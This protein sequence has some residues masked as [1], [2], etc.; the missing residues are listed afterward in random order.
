MFVD[1]FISRP[2]FAIVCSLIIILAGLISIPALPLAQYPNIAPPKVS[3]TCNYTGASA[4]VVES[5]V[6]TP[7]EQQINGIDAVKYIESSSSN[8]G[9][10]S[11]TITFQLE[12][13]PDLATV[14]VQNRVNAVLGRLPDD[15][16]R[17]GVTVDKVANTFVLAIGLTSPDGK[18]SSQFLSNYADVY[19]KDALKRVPGVGNVE[20]FGE[21]TYS[22]RIWLD[23]LKL[24]RFQLTPDDV[25][26]A[27]AEQNTQV[28]SG[29]IGQAPSPESQRYQVSVRV[30][31]R[32]NTAEEFNNLIIKTGSDGTLVKLRDVGR[33]ELGSETYQNVVRFRNQNAVGL[34]IFQRSRANA[35]QVSEGVRKEVSR[36]AERFPPGL[37]YEYAFD[38]TLAVKESIHE[39]VKTLIEAVLLVTLVVFIFLQSLRGMI[40]PIITI[41]VSLIGTFAAM[42]A[43]GF[44]INTLTLFGLTLA[45][46]LVVDDAIVVIE[47]IARLIQARN[48]GGTEIASLAM[49]EVTGAVIATSLVLIAVFVPVAF[50][51]GTAGQ[52]YRQFAL[53]IA[54]SVGISMFNA[55]TLTP[56]LSALWLK[57]TTGKKSNIVFRL[58]N[59]L[60]DFV[61]NCYEKML[62]LTLQAKPFVLI[63]FIACLGAIAWLWKTIPSSFV[64]NEDQGYFII[65]VQAPQGVSLHYTVD[66]LKQIEKIMDT[67]PE[68][69]S[70]F[71]VAGY[72]FTGSNPNNGIIFASM[73]PWEERKSSGQSLDEVINRIRPL[74][75]TIT[76]AQVIPFNPPPIEGLSNFGG[77]QFEIQDLLGGDIERLARSTGTLVQRTYSTASVS[78]A[79]T[80]FSSSSPQLIIDVDRDTA[81]R[82][83]I[84][85]KNAFSVLGI[86]LGSRYVNDFD[87]GTRIYRVYVQADQEFRSNPRN[88]GEFYVRSDTGKMVSL[89]NILAIERTSAPQTINHFNLF[90][91]AEINGAA[92]PGFSS[93]Q[94]IKSMEKLAR[95]TLPRDMS[96]EWSGLSREELETGP[97]SLILFALGLIIVF[98]VLAAQYESF[99]DPVIIM[100]SVP[101]AILGALLS[102]WLR[103]LNNDVFCQIGLVMLI[104]LASKNAILIVE[105]A[106]H[107]KREGL[108]AEAAILQS[109]RI[110]FRPII[111]TSMTCIIG[112]LPLVF[113]SGA[114]ANSRHSLGTA[115]FGGMI[116]STLLS[117]FL[118]P[119][120]Y[121]LV[122]LLR[123]QLKKITR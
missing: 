107:L 70:A 5:A 50:F 29:Q 65:L 8:D 100:F 1:F 87:L 72:S 83:R 15:V 40:I 41:P 84:N 71:G 30:K 109:C 32:L 85:L 104:G 21:G 57:P 108:A 33:V 75:S 27:V 51:P 121:L 35:M 93:G 13:N 52:L 16:K 47:N 90:R 88:I 73:K 78:G 31:G 115:V 92:A 113:A 48:T 54:F 86:F 20:V 106:N 117:L 114:G 23:P 34:G 19:I 81:K 89:K 102:Q 26:E 11:I 44:S 122:D 119:V 28:P 9:T 37:K 99:M 7:L 4:A 67:I 42:N 76:E 69:E 105:F 18:Y 80:S 6:T 59:Q 82:L 110:R 60:I 53:T 39:V 120:I 49:K 43:L 38:T 2:I 112:I 14:D 68:I 103:G 118:V 98:L 111:M 79:F 101:L 36:L 62:R 56:A 3:V 46:G 64:P 66:V 25:V 45:T 55:L 17:T 74:L 10:S 116:I 12:R 97:Q 94:A 95:E 77:F 91:A 58:F 22:M 63:I 123:K 96:F 24:S 61:I